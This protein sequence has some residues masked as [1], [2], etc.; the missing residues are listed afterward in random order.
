MSHPDNRRVEVGGRAADHEIDDDTPDGVV[1]VVVVV[2]LLYNIHT[3][4]F[5]GFVGIELRHT[6][7]EESY[8]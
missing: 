4:Q 6:I 7:A 1:G 8:I 3:H 2:V 5:H